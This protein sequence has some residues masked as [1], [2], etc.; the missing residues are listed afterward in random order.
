MR[1]L[2]AWLPC[3]SF[4]LMLC[5]CQPA[6]EP[7]EDLGGPVP[8][9]DEPLLF[10]VHPYDTPSFLVGRFQP[11]CDYLALRLG[12]P[13]QFYLGHSY[14][15]TVRRLSAGQVD[16]AYLGPTL[17]LRAHDHYLG[18]GVEPNIRILAGETV[19][20]ESGFSSVLVALESGPIETAL[21]LHGQSLAFG[22][23][24]SFSGHFVPRVMLH[25]AGISLADLKDYAFLDRH[26]RVALA[27]VHGDF[28]AGGL[29]KE[30]AERYLDRGLKIVA[31]SAL[32]SP[33][34]IV[35]KPGLDHAIST[36]VSQALISPTPEAA[37][38]FAFLGPGIGFAPVED[39]AFDVVRR[40]VRAIESAQPAEGLLW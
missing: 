13:V 5:A 35:A 4:C 38:A 14:G 29:R 11:L 22:E 21:D 9:S 40:T 27:V 17:Y 28:A 19:A 18:A 16:L 31:E 26:E 34:V 1:H 3:F 8:P 15:D 6:H 25:Q 20:G 12:R 39:S 30:V 7:A 23:P 33:H 10:A 37:S 32:L 36:A 2:R 24:R